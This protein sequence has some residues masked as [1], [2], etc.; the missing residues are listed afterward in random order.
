ME[1]DAQVGRGSHRLSDMGTWVF[2]ALARLGRASV[3]S[4]STGLRTRTLA[5]RSVMSWE[6]CAADDI[7][8]SLQAYAQ[9]RFNTFCKHL[10]N[11]AQRPTPLSH[12]RHSCEC[13]NSLASIV[14]T[15]LVAASRWS[16]Y[17]TA[18]GRRLAMVAR[19]QQSK[20]C[21]SLHPDR[22]TSSLLLHG[23]TVRG[24]A[25]MAAL[26]F[27]FASPIRNPFRSSGNIV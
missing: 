19:P 21:P 13:R 3:S 23:L 15:V 18:T 16:D 11:C 10:H 20:I 4:F 17:V 8:A 22:L 27:T 24:R 26:T 7:Y 9:V 1:H 2:D 25:H 12:N 6:L 14:S 5:T